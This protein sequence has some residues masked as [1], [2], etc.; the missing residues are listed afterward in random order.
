MWGPWF[1]SRKEG[2]RTTWTFRALV[3]VGFIALALL[4][5]SVWE[6]GVGRSLVCEERTPIADAILIDNLDWQYLVFER[7][8]RLYKAGVSPRVIV[9]VPAA[10]EPGRASIEERIVDVMT[11]G[12]RL[13]HTEHVPVTLDEPISLNVARQVR[14]F[15]TRE[16]IRSVTLVSPGFRS[17]RSFLVYENALKEAGVTVS[18][19]PVFGPR[20]PE[21]WTSS[22]HGLQE[23]MLQLIKLQYYRFYVL[24]FLGS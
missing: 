14:Q 3:L 1:F 17:R 4:T 22:W 10:A 6:P 16:R 24:P 7:A 13:P 5:R 12:A 2:L 18:C 15:V 9:P 21:D 8:A 19:V 11:Q 23:V 20:T